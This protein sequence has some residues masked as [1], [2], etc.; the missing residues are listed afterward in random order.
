MYIPKL[1]KNTDIEAAKAYI[2]QHSFGI[3]TTSD[4]NG[5]PLATH[6]PIELE[7][8]SKGEE[9]L[10]GHI[11]KANPQWKTFDSGRPV[12]AI[13]SAHHNYISS[14]WYEHAETVPTWNYVAVHVYGNIRIL[15]KE[16]LRASL[17]KLVAK[18]EQA[19]K[20]PVDLDTMNEKMVNRE[21]RGIVGFE[22]SITDIQAKHKLSQNRHEED[23]DTIID[24]LKEVG[25]AN[26][27]GIAEKM[28]ELVTSKK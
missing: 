5:L 7:T 11:S 12:L 4:E 25:D 10:I 6:I 2:H 17:K 28:E 15:D 8:N 13:F 9:V 23:F 16:E 19:S 24:E 1:Y 3:L 20:N 26:S 27:L 18:Y 21:M 14:S 22:I